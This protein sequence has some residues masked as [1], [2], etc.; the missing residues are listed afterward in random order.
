[1]NIHE[2]KI[3][4]QFLKSSLNMFSRVKDRS[5]PLFTSVI[6]NIEIIF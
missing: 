4:Q 1:M 6:L 3:N 5:T 2:L